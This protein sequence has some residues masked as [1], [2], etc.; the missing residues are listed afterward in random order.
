MHK[1]DPPKEDSIIMNVIFLGLHFVI[2]G[3]G[4]ITLVG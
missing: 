4:S 1:Q 2:G 3:A